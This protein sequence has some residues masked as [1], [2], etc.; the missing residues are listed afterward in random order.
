MIIDLLRIGIEC[1]FFGIG[2]IVGVYALIAI[3]DSPKNKHELLEQGY[4]EA[5]KDITVLHWYWD[6]DKDRYI[7]IDIVDR[8]E[9][10]NQKCN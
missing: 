3:C 7:L 10:I 9:E 2:V 8:D 4:K 1:I 5:V 6:S